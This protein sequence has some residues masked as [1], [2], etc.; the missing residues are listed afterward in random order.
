[1]AAIATSPKSGKVDGASKSSLEKLSDIK[2][3]LNNNAKQMAS[4]MKYAFFEDI[5]FDETIERIFK[6][7]NNVDANKNSDVLKVSLLKEKAVLISN[8]FLSQNERCIKFNVGGVNVL[9]YISF[10]QNKVNEANIR[11]KL[12]IGGISLMDENLGA[13]KLRQSKTV[14]YSNGIS[15][16]NPTIKF[17]DNNNELIVKLRGSVGLPPFRASFGEYVKKVNLGNMYNNNYNKQVAKAV[18]AKS[19]EKKEET[20]SFCD[21]NVFVYN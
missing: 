17:N 18:D 1:M 2:H 8:I 15:Y 7:I 16:A 13:F 6:L 14:Y 4:V 19:D 12:S 20:V 5:S 21:D 3:A 11:L 10:G 9:I